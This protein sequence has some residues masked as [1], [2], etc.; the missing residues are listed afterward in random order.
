M[1][2]RIAALLVLVASACS[3]GNGSGSSIDAPACGE[4]G[5]VVLDG[6]LDGKSVQQSVRTGSYILNQLADPKEL[7][8]GFDGGGSVKLEW[9]QLVANGGT[10]TVS[11]GVLRLPGEAADRTADS[12]VLFKGTDDTQASLTFAGGRV[13]MCIKSNAR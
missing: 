5:T 1:N 7:T 9:A 6:T 3:T 4:P 12:G 10:T 11:R 2:V 8:V 13:G